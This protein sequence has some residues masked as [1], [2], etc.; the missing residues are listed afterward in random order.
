MGRKKAVQI[1]PCKMRLLIICFL[2]GVSHAFPNQR[3]TGRTSNLLTNVFDSLF[4]PIDGYYDTEPIVPLVEPNN[5]PAPNSLF[6][7]IPG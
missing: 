5:S 1:Q 6:V 4:V 7:P 3:Q 2:A